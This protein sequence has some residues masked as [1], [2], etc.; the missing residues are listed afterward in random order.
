L[1]RTS[2]LPAT[3]PTD[4]AELQQWLIGIV[5]LGEAAAL[6]GIHPETYKRRAKA[7]GRELIQLGARAVGDYRWRALCLP[8]PLGH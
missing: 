6:R 1:K 4:P 7:E 3:S 5:R 2:S 8:N